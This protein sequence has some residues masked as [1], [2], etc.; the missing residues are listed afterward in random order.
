MYSKVVGHFMD[1][2][3]LKKTQISVFGALLK[4]NRCCLHCF[5]NST[6]LV[7]SNDFVVEVWMT[8]NGHAPE[9]FYGIAGVHGNGISFDR[10][11]P[12]A[13]RMVIFPLNPGMK[14]LIYLCVNWLNNLQ[15]NDKYQLIKWEWTQ[16]N[17]RITWNNTWT[18]QW[19]Q[20]GKWC[21]K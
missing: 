5:V 4:K 16:N 18:K 14:L 6:V 20:I 2:N 10:S 7:N 3:A 9:P 15:K 19:K 11:I 8:C 21:G 13:P 17:T 12:K 1:Q